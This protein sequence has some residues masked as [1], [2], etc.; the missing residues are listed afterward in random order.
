[1]S[2]KELAEIK[3]LP[4][5]SIKNTVL[6]PYIVMPFIGG[7]PELKGGSRSSSG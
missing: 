3:V 6:F 7:T 2:E 5:L 4:L 1:M